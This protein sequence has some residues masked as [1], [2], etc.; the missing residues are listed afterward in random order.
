VD[1]DVALVLPPGVAVGAVESVLRQA[2]GPL[3]ERLEL[4]DE[5]R[6]PEFTG[7]ARSVA[8]HCVFRD[9]TRTLRAEEAE[10]QLAA[11]LKA[12]EAEL[13]VRRRTS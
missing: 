12:L 9:P 11:A 5:Y 7:G 3:L 8:W 6:G 13:G 10:R 4:F 1:V 2:A